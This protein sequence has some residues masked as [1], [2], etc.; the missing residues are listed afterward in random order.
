VGSLRIENY[1]RD[2]NNRG[3]VINYFLLAD[4]MAGTARVRRW[5]FRG[6]RGPYVYNAYVVSIIV[7]KRPRLFGDDC[8]KNENYT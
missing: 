3:S 1:L 4:E 6:V 5:Q 2:Q 8:D 7:C